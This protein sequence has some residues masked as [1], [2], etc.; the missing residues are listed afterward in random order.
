MG[1]NDH[2]KKKI[3]IRITVALTIVTI[4][5]TILTWDLPPD[6]PV[7]LNS[8]LVPSFDRKVK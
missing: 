2:D 4:T 5:I 3:T 8:P 7:I 6:S 1:N